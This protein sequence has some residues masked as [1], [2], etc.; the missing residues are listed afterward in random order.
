M[1]VCMSVC[2]RGGSSC[3]ELYVFKPKG[4][5][6]LMKVKMLPSLFLPSHSLAVL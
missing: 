2:V 4:T 3:T 1:R 5:G 6:W